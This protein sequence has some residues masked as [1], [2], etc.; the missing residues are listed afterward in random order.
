MIVE[1][2]A[3]N[4]ARMSEGSEQAGMILGFGLNGI[5]S[6]M[7]PTLRHE[8]LAQENSFTTM[9][10]LLGLCANLA[11]TG[12][13]ATW[14]VVSLHI[15]AMLPACTTELEIPRL[16]TL[17]APF[18]LGLLFIE[19]HNSH[20]AK[21]LLGEISKK[22]SPLSIFGGGNGNSSTANVN[23]TENNHSAADREAHSLC[24]GIIAG[25]T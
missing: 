18:A 5:L 14:K 15:G 7:P 4:K 6:S 21:V 24:S 23:P 11:G 20:V 9:A 8:Y 16:A 10:M 17:V 25:E 3:H 19:T 22:Y 2:F 13:I 12:D 1:R